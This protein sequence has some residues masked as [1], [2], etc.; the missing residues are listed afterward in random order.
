MRTRSLPQVVSQWK[1]G[2]K[3]V[4]PKAADSIADPLDYPNLFDGLELALRAEEW[5][6]GHR[7]QDASATIYPEH[8]LDNESDLLEHMRLQTVEAEAQALEAKAAEEESEAAEEVAME[9][10]VVAEPG[11]DGVDADAVEEPVA[12]AA[13]AGGGE[14]EEEFQEAEAEAESTP[15]EPSAADLEAELEAELGAEPELSNG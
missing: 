11:A 1:A 6:K 2:L 7:L 15:A 4:N 14:E 12:A 9:A 8:A 5:L 13:A 3:E 10:A